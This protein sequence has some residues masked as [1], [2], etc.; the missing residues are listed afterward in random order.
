[1]SCLMLQI[2]GGGLLN[3]CSMLS[4]LLLLFPLPV[5][6]SAPIRI[7]LLVRIAVDMSESQ[8]L[9]LPVGADSNLTA[10]D[11]H[12]TRSQK[13]FPFGDP[14]KTVTAPLTTPPPN[15][16]ETK[17]TIQFKVGEEVGEKSQWNVLKKLGEG[18][19]GAVYLVKGNTEETQYAL[20]VE[21][22]TDPRK[23]LRME[24]YAL[25]EL[26]KKRVQDRGHFVEMKDKGHIPGKYYY[27]V[28]TL[29]GESL[30]DLRAKQPLKKFSMGT[31]I[32][33]SRQCLEAI[34][35]LHKNGFLHRDIKPGNYM[36]GRRE[37]SQLRKVFIIDFGMCRK[38]TKD[39]GST[40]RNP[41]GRAGFRGTVKYASIACHVA[42]EHWLYQTVE[43]TCGKLPWRNIKDMDEVGKFKKDCKEARQKCLFGGCPREYAKIFPILDKGKFFDEP[44]YAAIFKLLDDAMVHTHS[45]DSVYDWE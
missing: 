34:E 21:A 13:E 9:W 37:L 10:A 2:G 20:K 29:V 39:D 35:D 3:V 22:E 1:M 26:G 6:W 30:Q 43:V 44:D 45:K 24:V 7:R 40:L 11:S 31:A 25:R 23:L 19:F 8:R 14:L 32:S 38:F 36:V 41:R 42:R 5:R 16:G 12:Q 17:K 27:I 15:P 18:A 33:V 4:L 28:M